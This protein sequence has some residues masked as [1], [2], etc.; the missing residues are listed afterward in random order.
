MDHGGGSASGPLPVWQMQTGSGQRGLHRLSPR[1][2][3]SSPLSSP[4]ELGVFA[5]SFRIPEEA[6]P[7]GHEDAEAAA[8]EQREGQQRAGKAAQ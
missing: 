3:G 6:E 4:R 7:A 8:R 5:K 1:L 2:S